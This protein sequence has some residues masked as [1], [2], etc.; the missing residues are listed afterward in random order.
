MKHNIEHVVPVLALILSCLCSSCDS[1]LNNPV[2]I[3]TN[4]FISENCFQA[5]L[6]IEPDENA[7]GLVAKRESAFLKAKNSLLYDLAV[8]NLAR[9]CYDGQLKAG[10]IDKN[11]KA[12]EQ[13]LSRNALIDKIKRFVGSGNI[14]FVYYDEKNC[15][16]I[17]YRM[18]KIGL[19]KKLNEIINPKSEN[20]ET[21]ERS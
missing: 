21:S 17:G 8:E 15:M 14:A 13:A 4:G 10:T 19:K 11:A 2:E 16:I 20:P 1:N 7:L 9:Y 5:L 18:Y 12:A 6:K 3:N